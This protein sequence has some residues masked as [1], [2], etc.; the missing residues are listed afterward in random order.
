MWNKIYH[1]MTGTII[2]L[3]YVLTCSK[4]RVDSHQDQL[5]R[6]QIRKLLDL[7]LKWIFT[8]FAIEMIYLF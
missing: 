8:K 4:S 7:Q 2:H 6:E 3:W 1:L 5:Q